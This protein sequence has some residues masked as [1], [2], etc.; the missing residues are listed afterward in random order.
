MLL[1]I[2][3]T[4]IRLIRL[5]IASAF[6]LGVHYLVARLILPW[7]MMHRAEINSGG[8]AVLIVGVA[9]ICIF[10]YVLFTIGFC[11]YGIYSVS[12]LDWITLSKRLR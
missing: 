4:V 3:K 5:I 1:H 12:P 6:V 9:A 8:F 2:L 7:A 11:I 10:E